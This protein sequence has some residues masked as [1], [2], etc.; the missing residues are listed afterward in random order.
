MKSKFRIGIVLFGLILP[1]LGV[2]VF[3]VVLLKQKAKLEKTFAERKAKNTQNALLQKKAKLIKSQLAAYDGKDE[4][5]RQLVSDSDVSSLN[6]ALKE[7]SNSFADRRTFNQT[8]FQFDN[9]DQ[10]IGAAS[11]QPSFS[12]S[13]SL[14]GTYSSIQGGLLALESRMPHLS[15]NTMNLSKQDD[16]QLLSAKLTY[17][18]WSVSYT[19]LT[20]PTTPYV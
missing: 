6:K 19:H 13:M 1:L 7:I 15:L 5:W 4:R 2:S 11:S 8:D 20:L 9:N 10:G 16:S 18:A 14:N 17:S 3:S 12:F